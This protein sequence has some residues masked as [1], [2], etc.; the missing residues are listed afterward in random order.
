MAAGRLRLPC[1]LPSEENKQTMHKNIKTVAGCFTNVT[2]NVTATDGREVELT[3][4]VAI[5]QERRPVP[6]AGANL[7]A[8]PAVEYG[9]HLY[10]IRADGKPLIFGFLLVRPSAFPVAEGTVDY[11]LTAT[12]DSV[13]ALHVDIEL[14]PGPR[15][16]SAYEVA[17]LEG[18][19]GT[20][21]EW[22][23]SMRKQTATLAVEQVT[24][25]MQRAETAAQEAETEKQNA[26]QHVQTARQFA[27]K[28]E[29]NA[30]EAETQATQAEDSRIQAAAEVKKAAAEVD[31][32]T[33]EREAAAGHANAA[34]KSAQ[35][36]Q[37]AQQGAEKAAQDAAA[38]KVGA[39]AA[40]DEANAHKN[41]AQ[42]AEAAAK[43]A[44]DK[45]AADKAAAEQAKQDA[46]A[47]QTKAE[48]EA[49]KA[50]AAADDAAEKGWA[51]GYPV[52]SFNVSDSLAEIWAK[53]AA[54][55]ACQ[56]VA[57]DV[58]GSFDNPRVSEIVSG[59]PK[60]AATKLALRNKN[61]FFRQGG[62]FCVKVFPSVKEL[63]VYQSSGNSL[64]NN[65]NV[66]YLEVQLLNET[67]K[68]W[69]SYI[70]S[71]VY[72]TVVVHAKTIAT[73]VYCAMYKMNN[74]NVARFFDVKNQ[75]NV[76]YFFK[77]NSVKDKSQ[78]AAGAVSK[79]IWENVEVAT[80]T[81]CNS[82]ALPEVY[83]PEALPKLST[84]DKMFDNC[85][86]SAGYL[87]KL[88]PTLPPWTDGAEHLLT[89][90]MHID[91]QADEDLR[92]A[93]DSAAARGWTISK[94]WNGTSTAA[95]FALRPAPPMPI[96]AK[97]EAHT[98]EEGNE[99]RTLSWC[100]EVTS[101]DGKEP[102]ELGYTLFDSV[103]DAREHYGLPEPEEPETACEL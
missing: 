26:A 53:L 54:V 45:A 66:D 57:L 96:Y 8:F 44:A 2:C 91:H 33:Q 63:F 48:Q 99:Q 39:E 101:P 72:K 3:A 9:Q 80:E 95:T 1:C 74:G 89:L 14:T 38:E 28:A 36:A 70:A 103:E 76:S 67:A 40:A 64:W 13:D 20:E 58:E 77:S 75:P 24:P 102:E 82:W 69:S 73:D 93:I 50:E 41:A 60:C 23:E 34:E 62:D 12:L 16:Y 84:A 49:S 68:N 97:V 25:L 43:D 30:T 46:Q 19:E 10:E 52:V 55:A 6:K 4:Y 92:T 31:K 21:A 11:T 78:L 98:D 87:L 15:G 7:F 29:D 59:A 17:V 51:R 32:A 27:S 37:A 71:G 79:E 61:G 88:L 56:A 94:Q 35:A 100:H 18:F 85:R 42:A 81:F 22:L 90:G 5:G 83:L 86:L 47:A 65:V